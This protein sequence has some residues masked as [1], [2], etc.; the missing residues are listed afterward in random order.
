[1]DLECRGRSQGD[2]VV[3]PEREQ[4][5]R[6]RGSGTRRRRRLLTG[7]DSGGSLTRSSVDDGGTAAWW[8]GRGVAVLERMG[9]RSRFSSLASA[10]ETGS[11]R[12]E[13]SGGESSPRENSRIGVRYPP[14]VGLPNSKNVWPGVGNR[15][16][17]RPG[18]NRGIPPGFLFPKGALVVTLKSL[19]TRRAASCRSYHHFLLGASEHQFVAMLNARI[20]RNEMDHSNS[21]VQNSRRGTPKTSSTLVNNNTSQ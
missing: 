11:R 12:H 10:R 5:R 2:G 1:V 15:V 18:E 17:E 8:S 7:G 3:D 4:T 13:S 9:R 16:G 21:G 19:L 6:H 20:I 14:D